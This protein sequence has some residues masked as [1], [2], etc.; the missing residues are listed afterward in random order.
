SPTPSGLVVFLLDSI[1]LLVLSRRAAAALGLPNGRFLALAL[2]ALGGCSALTAR[3]LPFAL[4]LA[5]FWL[6]AALYLASVWWLNRRSEREGAGVAGRVEADALGLAL[7]TFAFL[8][9]TLRT[10]GLVLQLIP[11]LYAVPT[12]LA[13]VA[14]VPTARHLARLADDP[15]RVA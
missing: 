10:G 1:A 11:A 4:G 2:I 13:A 9:G 12:M 8:A 14:G 3:G 5:T 6:L 7:L 15:H